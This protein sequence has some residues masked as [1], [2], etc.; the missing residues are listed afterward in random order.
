MAAVFPQDTTQPWVN[1]GVT[2]KYDDIEDRWYVISTSA[3][4]ELV[5]NIDTLNQD[6]IKGFDTVEELIESSTSR[7]NQQDAAIAELDGRLD[8]IADN[9]GVLEFKGLYK[10]ELHKSASA[11]AEALQVCNAENAFSPECNRAYTIC[12]DNI[13]QPL[14]PGKM[15]SWGSTETLDQSL[16]EHLLFHNTDANTETFDWVNTINIG[17]YVE[18]VEKTQ[19]DSV[20]Y[21]VLQV[22]VST[23]GPTINTQVNVRFLKETGNGDGSFNLQENYDIRIFKKDL[24]LDVN[25]AD[26][27]YVQKPYSVYFADTSTEIN[28]IAEAGLK[29]GEMWYD[30]STLELFVWNLNAWTPVA[31]PISADNSFLSLVADVDALQN[32]A[33]EALL[34]NN[35]YYSESPPAGDSTGTLR[36]GDLWVDSDDLQIKFY[37]GDAWINPD[38]QGGG[39]YLETTGGELT[40]SLKIKGNNSEYGLRVETSTGSL[41]LDVSDK[42]V[43]I[44]PKARFQNGFV[45]KEGDSI[46][47][48]N[49]MFANNDYVNY[50]GRISSETDIVNKKYVDDKFSQSG[51]A[52][53][54]FVYKA[55]TGLSDNAVWQN[56]ANDGKFTTDNFGNNSHFW[57]FSDIDQNGKLL[58]L[59]EM[60]SGNIALYIQIGHYQHPYLTDKDVNREGMKIVFSGIVSQ[61]SRPTT[62]KANNKTYVPA[63]ELFLETGTNGNSVSSGTITDGGTYY[64][65]FGGLI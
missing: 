48:E 22:D 18:I 17:D 9:I 36:N 65:K 14:A 55:A 32:Q 39:D 64:I 44:Y 33:E 41:N 54:V 37:S 56:S 23:L 8:Q 43:D 26:N 20:L 51:S 47:G 59:K 12:M 49:V 52:A 50:N 28:P 15:T 1:N 58:N 10:Y 5:S 35:I 40:G 11:C 24:G 61:T 30:T 3:S 13:D 31:Q 45:I 7:D 21:E 29:N 19:G 4:D 25:E 2:Y 42:N 6:V 62:G 53:D 60:S 63:W 27:R 38:L 46:A 16:T 34:E 57:T